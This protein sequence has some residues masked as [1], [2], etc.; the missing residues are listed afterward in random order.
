[1][2]TYATHTS[3]Y[4]HS[5]H[6]TTAHHSTYMYLGIMENSMLCIIFIHTLCLS[7]LV[8][9]ARS[10]VSE[11]P[12][13]TISTLWSIT[14]AKGNQLKIFWRSFKILLP[15]SCKWNTFKEKWIE[16]IDHT[17]MRLQWVMRLLTTHKWDYWPHTNETNGLWD[18]WPL[19]LLKTQSA[20]LIP[21]TF[22]QIQLIAPHGPLAVH[23]Y[24]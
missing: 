7:I 10:V 18:T 21:Y 20:I 5:P 12:P 17:Q 6:H 15:W 16:Y 23:V 19:S 3:H 22:C 24:A 2:E 13:C 1:M 14:V 11:I 8:M 4:T 9:S